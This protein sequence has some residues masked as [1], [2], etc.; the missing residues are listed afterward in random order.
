MTVFISVSV[1][2]I[3]SFRVLIVYEV[4]TIEN[5]RQNGNTVYR[6]TDAIM[7]KKQLNNRFVYSKCLL[8]TIGR[9]PDPKTDL[10]KANWFEHKHFHFIS[11][12]LLNVETCIFKKKQ[13]YFI[14]A[15][16]KHSYLLKQL[17][18][19]FASELSSQYFLFNK[20]PN[21][22]QWT[23]TPRWV[24]YD[25]NLTATWRRGLIARPLS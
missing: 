25:A 20:C 14:S 12:Q 5:K 11:V 19:K 16:G 24:Y 4:G 2:T 3:I 22:E 7:H 15:N 13:G 8:S 9:F 18:N 23:N 17:L 21:S 1:W 6:P 10:E